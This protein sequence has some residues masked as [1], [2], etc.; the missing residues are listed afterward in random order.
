MGTSQNSHADIPAPGNRTDDPRPDDSVF[1]DGL[2][3]NVTRMMIFLRNGCTLL[4]K[5]HQLL[6]FHPAKKIFFRLKDN[7]PA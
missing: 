7:R 4:L 1:A 6:L 5:Q 2:K 3:P